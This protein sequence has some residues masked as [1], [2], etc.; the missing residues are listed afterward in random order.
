MSGITVRPAWPTT[1]ATRTTASACGQIQLDFIDDPR[2]AALDADRLAGELLQAGADELA[3]R[4]KELAA[5]PGDAAA[6]DT[7]H[8]RQSVRRYREFVDALAQTMD[9]FGES[10]Q[11]ASLEMPE[12]T[13]SAKTARPRPSTSRCGKRRRKRRIST[14]SRGPNRWVGARRSGPNR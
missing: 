3:R 2:K 14:V 9:G 13:S 1:R 10:E 11:V 12:T 6:P 4:R 7:E 8:L 5:K